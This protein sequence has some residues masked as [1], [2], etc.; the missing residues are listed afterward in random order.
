[1]KQFGTKKIF[2]IFLN[3]FLENPRKNFWWNFQK[4][5]L[6]KN[7]NKYI[8][9]LLKQSTQL[10][11]FEQFPHDSLNYFLKRAISRV[12]L[13][14]EIWI[15][16]EKVFWCPNEFVNEIS[17]KN[18]GRNILKESEELFLEDLSEEFL[19]KFLTNPLTNFIILS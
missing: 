10:Q 15:T 9:E 8:G 18:P 17:Q 11:I 1:M 7:L 19:E 3:E 12:I 16:F 4:K 6:H 2:Y 14:K 13:Q 5:T